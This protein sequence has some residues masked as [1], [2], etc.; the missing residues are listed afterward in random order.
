MKTM[1]QMARGVDNLP[2][3]IGR[4][5]DLLPAQMRTA[6]RNYGETVLAS[7]ALIRETVLNPAFHKQQFIPLGLEVAIKTALRIVDKYFPDAPREI[8]V[9]M[10]CHAAIPAS[11]WKSLVIDCESSEMPSPTPSGGANGFTKHASTNG[12]GKRPVPSPPVDGT[13]GSAATERERPSS[14]P[15]SEVGIWRGLQTRG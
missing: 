4:R 8:E 5:P 11:V 10:N 1:V 15:D 2:S 13:Q 12:N 14:S 7:T 3:T 9:D 6:N